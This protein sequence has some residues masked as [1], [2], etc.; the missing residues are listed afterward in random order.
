V[1]VDDD[2]PTHRGAAVSLRV[3]SGF[4]GASILSLTAPSPSL[5]SGVALGGSTVAED[6]SW[7]GPSRLSHAPNK[8]GVITVAIA[9]SSAALLTVSPKSP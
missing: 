6:G 2:P 9:P 5:L 4:G 1:I 8:N 7:S 3:P